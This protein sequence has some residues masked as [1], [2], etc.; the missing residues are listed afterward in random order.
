MKSLV[1]AVAVF[2]AHPAFAQ[3]TLPDGPGKDQ[4]LNVCGSVTKRQK[5]RPSD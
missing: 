3:D 1:A 5:P 2:L 4:T